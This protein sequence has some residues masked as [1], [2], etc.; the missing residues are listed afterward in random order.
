MLKVKTKVA[1]SKIHGLGLFADQD[2]QEGQ[3]IWEFTPNVDRAIH[4]SQVMALGEPMS[5]TIL[6]YSCE[7]YKEVS[8]PIHDRKGN[9]LIYINWGDIHFINHSSWPNTREIVGCNVRLTI[10]QARLFIAS[11]EELTADYRQYDARWRDGIPKEL[12]DE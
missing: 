8:F 3:V 10:T 6:Y 9:G 5:S 4:V 1:P 2:I 7:E 12:W 11:G